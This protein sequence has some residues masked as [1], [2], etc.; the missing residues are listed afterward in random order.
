MKR[1]GEVTDKERHFSF[2][3]KYHASTKP[4]N[5]TEIILFC[6]MCNTKHNKNKQFQYTRLNQQHGEGKFSVHISFYIK[7]D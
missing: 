2:D 7:A 5:Q 6:S 4:E 1:I 3:V